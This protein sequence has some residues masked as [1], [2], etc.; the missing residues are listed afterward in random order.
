[1]KIKLSKQQWQFIGKK[2]GWMKKAVIND[3]GYADGG[4][5][6][7]EDEMDLMEKEN[8][9]SIFKLIEDWK[10]QGYGIALLSPDD[11]II[12]P[13]IDPSD[14]PDMVLDKSG[15]GARIISGKYKGGMIMF[16]SGQFEDKIEQPFSEDKR[17]YITKG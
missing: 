3:D 8:G 7:T 10:D 11:I 2:T 13:Y 6:Y 16:H 9:V 1:M 15:N 17:T 4:E 14:Y 12:E 5:P